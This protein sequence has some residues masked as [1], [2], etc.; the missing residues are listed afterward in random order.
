MNGKS[1][2]DEIDR[3]I[4]NELTGDAEKPYSQIAKSLDV[5]NTMIHQRIA[6][7][8][9]L[10]VIEH[11]EIKLNEKILGYGSSAFTGIIL[12]EV[13]NTARVIEALQ[14]VPEVV[15]CYFVSGAYNLFVKIIAQNND[16]LMHVLYDKIDSIKGIVRTETLINFRTVIKRGCPIPEE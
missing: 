4:L 2:L 12:K 14:K 16:H 3:K 15:E 13:A 6:R 11:T 5:S 7:M 8:K 9:Q 1:A 10:G